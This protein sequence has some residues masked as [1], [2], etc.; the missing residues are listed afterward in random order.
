MAKYTGTIKHAYNSR[1]IP[2]AS[3]IAYSGKTNIGGTAADG[4]GNFFLETD[5]EADTLAISAVGYSAFRFHASEY[6]HLFELEPEDKVMDEVVII[7]PPKLPP[8]PQTPA[9]TSD[10]NKLY[11]LALAA[12]AIIVLSQKK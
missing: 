1:P 9:P 10:K 12:I 3:V 6:Q 5:S 2:Y 4:N 7:S 11:L 8:H